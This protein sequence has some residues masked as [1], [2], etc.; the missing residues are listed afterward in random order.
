M[1]HKY[2]PHDEMMEM[3]NRWLD[4]CPLC[5]R[6]LDFTAE[7]HH[8]VPKS[9]GGKATERLHKICHRKIH[10]TFS[11]KELEKKYNNVAALLENEEIQKFVAWVADKDPGFY[12][13]SRESKRRK[14][15]RKT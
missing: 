13:V 7:K 1:H 10:A 3:V 4:L 8:L 12:D 14:N 15:L 2:M 9:K 11:E 6:K 5:E